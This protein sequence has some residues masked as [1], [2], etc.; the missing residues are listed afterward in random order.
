MPQILPFL[1]FFNIFIIYATYLAHALGSTTEMII[2][3]TLVDDFVTFNI[4]NCKSYLHLSIK[5]QFNNR[6]TI[7]LNKV[8]WQD[9]F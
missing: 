8:Y 7:Q 4:L 9:V 3:I 6:N 1:P 5:L 2:S